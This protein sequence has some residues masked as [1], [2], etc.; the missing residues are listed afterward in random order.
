MSE[1]VATCHTDGCLN[2]GIPVVLVLD[3]DDPDAAPISV[4]MCGPCGQ[5]IADVVP[6]LPVKGV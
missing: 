4:V 6:P 2:S 1:H 3:R 5:P